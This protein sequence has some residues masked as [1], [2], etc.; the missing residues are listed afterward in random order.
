MKAVDPNPDDPDDDDAAKAV[1]AQGGIDEG[2]DIAGANRVIVELFKLIQSEAS[3]G[4]AGAFHEICDVAMLVEAVHAMC[5]FLDMERMG[6]EDDGEPIAKELAE[7]V[8]KRKFSAQRRREL[9]AEDKALPDGSYPIENADDLDN[10]AKLARSGHGDVAAAKRLISKRAKELGVPNPL[11]HDASKETEGVEPEVIETE[12]PAEEAVK[13]EA[14][15]VE[16]IV[17][18]A[19]AKASA[20]HEAALTELRDELAKVKATPIPGGPV[21][22]APAGATRERERDQNL[23]KAAHYERLAGLTSEQDMK[24]HYKAQAA[25]AREAAK[26]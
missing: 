22:T 9:A 20:D 18:E 5:C 11:A 8:M 24:T 21:V 10:A 14:P 3:E 7:F 15:D 23:A 16:A 12:T 25:A 1:N 6:D 2:P 4:A 19:V 17:K 26:A 13:D